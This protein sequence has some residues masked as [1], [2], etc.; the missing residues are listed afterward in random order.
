MYKIIRFYMHKDGSTHRRTIKSGLTLEEAQ[1][2]C[3]REDTCM[4]GNPTKYG[5][6]YR[7]WFDG[8]EACR[9]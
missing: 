8:Y 1:E 9:K 2:H 4:K 6:Q 7:G 5:S 3:K